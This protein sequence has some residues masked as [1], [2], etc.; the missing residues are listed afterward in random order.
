ME[1]I[2]CL[3]IVGYEAIESDLHLGSTFYTTLG[4]LVRVSFDYDGNQENPIHIQEIQAHEYGKSE[5]P[6]SHAQT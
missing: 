6:G 5:W 2:I 3:K 4:R 1:N